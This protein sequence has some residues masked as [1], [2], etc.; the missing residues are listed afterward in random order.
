LFVIKQNGKQGYI[1]KTGKIVAEPKFD[2]AYSFSEGLASVWIG[3][4]KGYIDK[5]G[6][7]VWEP[8]N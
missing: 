8:T 3:D 7:Y 1:D 4:K 6:K 5:T 2:R